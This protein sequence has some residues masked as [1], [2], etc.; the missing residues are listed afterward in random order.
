ML[1]LTLQFFCSDFRLLSSYT[2]ENYCSKL[3]ILK[4]IGQTILKEIGHLDFLKKNLVAKDSYEKEHS[5]C[6]SKYFSEISESRMGANHM[7]SA[8]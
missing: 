5:N 8:T 3:F 7:L 6:Q 4:E 1:N 2:F